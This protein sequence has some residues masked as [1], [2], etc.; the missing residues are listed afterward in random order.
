MVIKKFWISSLFAIEIY[1]SAFHCVKGLAWVLCFCFYLSLSSPFLKCVCELWA[2]LSHLILFSCDLSHSQFSTTAKTIPRICM[3]LFFISFLLLFRLLLSSFGG[4]WLKTCFIIAYQSL[5]MRLNAKWLL[6]PMSLRLRAFFN[7]TVF[8]SRFSCPL[9]PTM[10][11]SVSFYHL[12]EPSTN[13]C[14]RIDKNVTEKD[15]KNF[16][17]EHCRQLLLFQFRKCSSFDV[18]C[19]QILLLFHSSSFQIRC[20][21]LFLSIIIVV[22]VL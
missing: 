17:T 20:M 22:F 10:F 11:G 5:L 6:K 19:V 9:F 13:K 7:W 4:I 2:L 18:W 15:F 16:Q 8:L 21:Q 3:H 1:I 12:A 14:I